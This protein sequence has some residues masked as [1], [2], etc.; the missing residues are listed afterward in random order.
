MRHHAQDIS[1]AIADSCD[2]CDGAVGICVG[3]FAAI[4]S[5]VTKNDLIVAFESIKSCGIAEIISFAMA[6]GNSQQVAAMGG[7]GEG[8]VGGFHARV[9]VKAAVA[10][11]C[12]AKHGAGKKSGFEE[13]LESV[14]D[15]DYDAPGAGKFFNAAHDGRKARDGS[16]A[17]VVTESEAAW[18]N[19]DVRAGE[20]GGLMPDKF[21]LLAKD[22]MGDVECVVITI[23]AGKNDNAEFHV[24]TLD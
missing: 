21:S 4:G 7:A 15:T 1:F 10:Q 17:E 12:V 5:G 6:D 14:A 20:I 19:D 9:D 11:T 13:N 16:S 24:F 22:V 18:K 23:G 3:V 8:R 2:I